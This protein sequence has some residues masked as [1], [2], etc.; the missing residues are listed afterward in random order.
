M[1]A[2]ALDGEYAA[3]PRDWV[4]EQVEA[5]EASGGARANTLRD[6]GIPIY[7]LITKGHKSG[8]I[9]KSPLMRV[10]HDGVYAAVGSVGGAPQHPQWYH[11]LKA[12][13]QSVMIQDGPEPVDATAREV[14]GEE[15]ELWWE[16]AVAV[17]PRY[18][19]YKANTEREIPVFVITP[20]R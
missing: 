2:M 13:S 12:D 11:N 6:T 17:Y 19:E 16:R 9:R 20:T 4:R 7:I 8:K 1:C 18:A 15:R 10:E 14:F 3:S 5:Y